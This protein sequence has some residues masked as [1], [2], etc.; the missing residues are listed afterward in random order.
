MAKQITIGLDF[1]TH[2][3]KVC[4]EIIDG[5]ELTYQFS[6]FK[7]RN[8]IEQY[9]LP[10][11]IG[12]TEK[13]LLQYGYLPN[14]FKG[15]IIRDFKQNVF[16]T[17]KRPSMSF[18]DAI[19]Y[20]IWYI[21]YVIF[22]LEER[23]GINFTIQMGVPTD[24]DKEHM[25]KAKQIVKQ[26]VLS[27][28]KLVE[29]VYS[30]NINDFLSTPINVLKQKTKITNQFDN[31]DPLVFPEAYACL[32]P[33]ISQGKIPTGMNL[34]VDIGGGTT[35]ISFFTIE[36]N[37]PQVYNFFSI[38][39]GLNYLIKVDERYKNHDDSINI[40]EQQII[41]NSKDKQQ[42]KV[43]H[44]LKLLGTKLLEIISHNDKEALNIELDSN[45]NNSD[46]I[47]EERK[48]IYFREIEAICK[49]LEE[50]IK[51]EFKDNVK[52]I[53]LQN[54]L[55]A[56]QNRPIVYCG[57]GS[58]FKVLRKTY[59][60]YTDKKQISHTEWDQKSVVDME[61]IKQHNLCPILSTAYGLSKGAVDDNITMKSFNDLFKHLRDINTQPT[62]PQNHVR[63]T[64][65]YSNAYDDWDT[66]K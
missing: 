10:S 19:Y 21:S 56:L 48:K 31:M 42:K 54:L 8:G 45:V 3:T 37:Q 7:D 27:A 17:T 25:A 58:T 14:N 34:M 52:G 63:H 35:D 13:G 62:S 20:S 64:H 32:R 12:I 26:I 49:I 5:N 28:Y 47:D 44:D 15:K 29:E 22:Q 16:C 1:G 60:G 40:I 6:K 65:D 9:T 46:E 11:I 18:E 59:Q 55:D 33:L 4:A 36:N 51:H 50:N 66:I 57:G 2:Q 24:S 38:D 53:P 39:K 23:Y 43:F 61:Y 41:N 30:N